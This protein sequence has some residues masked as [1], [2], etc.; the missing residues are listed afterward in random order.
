[1][2][3]TEGIKKG[4]HNKTAIDILRKRSIS[5]ETLFSVIS[6]LIVLIFWESIV[7]LGLIPE[8]F[9][10]PPTRILKS[11]IDMLLSGE[12]IR[13]TW[14]TIQRVFVAFLIGA[15]PGLLLGLLMGWSRKI[16]VVLNPLVSALLPIPKI[17]LLPLI[18]LIFGVGETSRLV[19]ISMGVFFINL[20]NSLAGVQ[21]IDPIYFEAARNYGANKRQTFI[22][23]V[24]PGSSP[25]IFTGIRL[26]LG[27]ALLI[28]MG[29]EFIAARDGLGAMTWLAWQTLK[30]ET[31][32]VGIIVIALLGLVTTAVIEKIQKKILYWQ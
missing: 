25:M 31:L 6:P 23:V 26:S 21:N 5:P 10:P 1:M 29:I 8:L 13:E 9:F 3:K 20:I 32:Y 2:P 17:V 30:T 4:G 22:K 28:T 12:L 15:I 24:L 7:R 14:V 18:M 11:F 16:R 27:M 19:T